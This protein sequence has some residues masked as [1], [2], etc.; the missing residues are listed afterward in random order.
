MDDILHKPF[1]LA[2]MARTI[3]RLLP[4][5]AAAATSPPRE[6][7]PPEPHAAPSAAAEMGDVGALV[8]PAVID[9]L[10]Q[11]HSRGKGDFVRV[12][13]NEAADLVAG[14]IKRVRK[15]YGSHAIYAG[16]YGWQSAGAMG[17]AATLLHR[18]MNGY[19]GAMVLC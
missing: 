10:R 19:G 4:H 16:S 5:L 8:D 9:Q 7:A 12:S 18:L 11:M 6:S 3:A 1:T 13:W 14:E 17:D 15:A 2:A